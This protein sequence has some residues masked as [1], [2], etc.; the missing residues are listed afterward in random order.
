MNKSRKRGYMPSWTRLLFGAAACTVLA[1][2]IG[3]LCSDPRMGQVERP[4]LVIGPL[5]FPAA[6]F[7][8]L[9]RRMFLGALTAPLLSF[10]GALGALLPLYPDAEHWW[11]ALALL[12]SGSGFL[13]LVAGSLYGLLADPATSAPDTPPPDA[14]HC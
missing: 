6:A 11:L 10:A 2:A 5:L 9:A 7:G 1:M 3:S 12:G 14:A 8:L 13:C 4:V